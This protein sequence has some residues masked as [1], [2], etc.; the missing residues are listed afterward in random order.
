MEIRKQRNSEVSDSDS[1]LLPSYNEMS[2]SFYD[3]HDDDIISFKK[4]YSL[5]KRF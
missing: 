2:T 3:M 5:K 4:F 1:H